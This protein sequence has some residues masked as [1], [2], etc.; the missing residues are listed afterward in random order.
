MEFEN[1]Y[2]TYEEYVE[3]GGTLD[4]A[5]FNILEFEAQKNIDRYTFGRIKEIQEQA[6]EVKLCVFDLIKT[7][8]NYSKYA[9]QNKAIASESTDGYS[10]SYSA[11]N[12][13]I[14]KA[15]SSEVKNI[16]Y[17]YLSDLKTDKD[18]PYLYRG[19]DK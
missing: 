5:P 18:V 2:L 7:L 13:G 14:S 8:S 11:S 4:E 16:I 9:E 17:T 10:I 15:K 19:A 12:E 6:K 1:Q 3:L